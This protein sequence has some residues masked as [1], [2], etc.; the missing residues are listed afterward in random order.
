[1]ATRSSTSR[2]SR[3]R[4]AQIAA[5]LLPSSATCQANPAP[6]RR[7]ERQLARATFEVTS[8]GMLTFGTQ[9]QPLQDQVLPRRGNAESIGSTDHHAA[10]QGHFD[11]SALAEDERARILARANGGRSAARKRG[12]KFGPKPKLAPHQEREAVRMVCQD[13]QSLRAV[14]RHYHVGHSTIVRALE[15]ATSIA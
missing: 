12:V 7:L 6:D 9:R 4:Y 5:D 3:P 13:G 14:A 11:M 8:G 2:A 1:M 10:R 15:R